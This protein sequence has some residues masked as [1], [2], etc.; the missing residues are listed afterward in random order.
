[1]TTNAARERRNERRD[2]RQNRG[3]GYLRKRGKHSS[4][5]R[6]TRDRKVTPAAKTSSYEAI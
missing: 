3:C 1:M 4:G 5:M 2:N 6:V